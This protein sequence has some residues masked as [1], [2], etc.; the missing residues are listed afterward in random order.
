MRI[1]TGSDHA[2]L[3]LKQGLLEFLETQGHTVTDLG[4]HS[5]ESCDYPD[6]A[7]RLHDCWAGGLGKNRDLRPRRR[8]D[9]TE[10]M[11]Y[12]CFQRPIVQ[13]CDC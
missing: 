10:M 13:T 4:T 2:G 1:A 5:N 3:Q 11:L 8:R 7:G 12:Y 9:G 6:Y